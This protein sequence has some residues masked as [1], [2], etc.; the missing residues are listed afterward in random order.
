MTVI[1]KVVVAGASLSAIGWG[2]YAISHLLSGNTL[3]E[4]LKDKGYELLS[5]DISKKD[6]KST[7]DPIVKA[8]SSSATIFEGTKITITPS[9]SSAPSQDNVDALKRACEKVTSSKNYKDSDLL[10]AEQFCV[11]PKSIRE[12]IGKNRVT[13]K[14][15][16]DQTGEDSEWDIKV[17][18]YLTSGESKKISGISI[19]SSEPSDEKGK[20][21]RLKEA[22]STLGGKKTYDTDFHTSLPKFIDWCSVPK[23][24]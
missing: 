21:D 15:E 13:L 9:T 18:K 11:T 3:G 7:W 19:T 22:C 8:Y 14:V 16:K 24:P 1:A 5:F 4:V 23:K 6:D 20:R 2:G 17:Q 12:L 10:I